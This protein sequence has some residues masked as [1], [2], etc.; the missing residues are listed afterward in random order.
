MCQCGGAALHQHGSVAETPILVCLNPYID[1]KSVSCLNIRKPA[2]IE[3]VFRTKFN[4]AIGNR[5]P[6]RSDTDPQMIIKIPYNSIFK[7]NMILCR[8]KIFRCHEDKKSKHPLS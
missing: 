4:E 2:N 1:L 5:A 8:R 6:L 3:F 7:L